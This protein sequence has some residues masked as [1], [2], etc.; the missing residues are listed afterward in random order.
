MRVARAAPH[1]AMQQA[2]AEQSTTDS[3]EAEG[4][5]RNSNACSAVALGGSLGSSSVAKS[6]CARLQQRSIRQRTT[7][8]RLRD[9]PPIYHP[10]ARA[11]G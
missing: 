5:E 6:R 8:N 3:G 4:I 2:E 1:Q 7:K 9:A 11:K 10:G